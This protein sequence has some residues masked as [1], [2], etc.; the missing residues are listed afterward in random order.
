MP[1][2]CADSLFGDF[3]SVGRTEIHKARA[4]IRVG[5]CVEG[6]WYPDTRS[7]PKQFSTCRIRRR[8]R[9]WGSR[10]VCVCV[11]LPTIYHWSCETPG[12]KQGSKT[13]NSQIPPQK[14]KPGPDPEFLKTTKK[15]MRKK[16]FLVFLVF[17]YFFCFFEEFRGLGFWIPVA[18]RVSRNI[19]DKIIT[20]YI[21]N[22]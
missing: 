3:G 1:L 20:D 15:L 2:F 11:F 12:Q 5:N 17:F 21:L 19:G 10:C 22:R 13:P 14:K 16:Y 4:P 8:C 9:T 7:F 18:G 6:G